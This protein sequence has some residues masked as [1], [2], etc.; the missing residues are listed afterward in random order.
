MAAKQK[1]QQKPASKSP[2]TWRSSVAV[3]V[4]VV[5][6]MSFGAALTSLLPEGGLFAGDRARFHLRLDSAEGLTDA[7][8]IANG[9]DTS[10]NDVGALARL[11][12][13]R[14]HGA[15]DTERVTAEKLLQ[16]ASSSARLSPE[17]LYARALL[18]GLPRSL[19]PVADVRLDDELK[20]AK[21]TALVFLARAMRTPDPSERRALVE[22]AALGRDPTLHATHQL[23]RTALA[24]GD[25]AGA[26]AALDR[27][28]RL[29]GKHAAGAVTAVVVALIEDAAG[30]DQR[31]RPRK[32]N[33]G[34]PRPGQQEETISLDE[35]RAIELLD[36]GLDDLDEDQLAIT[37]LAAQLTRNG[38]ANKELLE[39][40][41][42]AAGRSG[43]NAQQLL[44]VFV[45]DA[46]ADNAD[47]VV[48]ALKSVDSLGL[49]VDVSRARFL[50]AIPDD[51]RRATQKRPRSTSAKGFQLPLGV[52]AFSFSHTSEGSSGVDVVDAVDMGLPWVAMPD[53]VFFPE[54]RV[55]Q[56]IASV[57]RGGSRDKLDIR[58]AVI[59][60]LGLAERASA[61]GDLAT[62]LTL[63]QQARDQV[64]N[65]ADVALVDAALRARQNDVAGVKS[66]LDTAVAAAP[67]DPRVLLL[68]ARRYLESDNQPGARKSLAAFKKLGLKSGPAAAVEAMIE[69][70][71]GDLPSA[72]AALAEA[73]RLSGD[74][75]V[76]T[77]RASVVV[78]RLVDAGEARRAADRLL[79]LNDSSG[80]DV[81]G[82][83]IAEAAYRKGDQPRAEAALKAIVDAKPWIGEAHLFYA[84]SIAFNP[85]RKKEAFGETLKAL[86]KIERGPLVE[87]AK[88]LALVLKRR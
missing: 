49:L 32:K 11:L 29:D 40:A 56:L 46:D 8:D 39:R 62:A 35:A 71:G 10:L 72:R 80:D 61:R 17:G 67:D 45:C 20:V 9:D 15:E 79:A 6:G 77:Q 64:G 25:V 86:D 83:W 1:Q 82:A 36:E 24:A 53:P 51:E 43:Q 74:D 37:L 23:A 13:W 16:K 21:A 78:N 76:L 48:K 57:E 87:E 14:E 38:E 31:K 84:Q 68:A 28:F 88:R 27:L 18:A 59:E 19:S 22:R 12:L 2:W 65:D 42:Q 75:D 69:A 34:A 3:A 58:L 63:L 54:R 47:A 70:R 85:A 55:R 4:F 52:L 7:A 50:R 26:R 81:V 30:P 33:E 60:K 66:A 73:K 5:V 41:L 44:E